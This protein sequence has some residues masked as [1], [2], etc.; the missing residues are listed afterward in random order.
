MKTSDFD[1]HLPD[2]LIAKSPLSERD[3]SR[4]LLLPKT[5]GNVEHRAFR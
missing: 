2:E 5:G 1:F 4:L 3:A